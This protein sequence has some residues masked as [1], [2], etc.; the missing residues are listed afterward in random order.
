MRN[1]H[2]ITKNTVYEKCDR[3]KILISSRMLYV[4]K[5][6]LCLNTISFPLKRFFILKLCGS[7]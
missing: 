1:L 6:D 3:K 7:V 2:Y 4:F 5:V